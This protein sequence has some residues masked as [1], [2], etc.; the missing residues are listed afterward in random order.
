MSAPTPEGTPAASA[1]PTTD[2]STHSTTAPTPCS[3]AEAGLPPIEL[4]TL[5]GANPMA[6]PTA[7]PAETD[8]RNFKR[9][10]CDLPLVMT[11]VLPN[12]TIGSCW[13]C[14]AIEISEGGCGVLSPRLLPANA[15][16]LIQVFSADG[17]SRRCLYAEVHH[18]KPY[19]RGQHHLIG[20]GF[21]P[22]PSSS[23]IRNWFRARNA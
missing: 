7:I 17:R 14:R 6:V 21:L 18:T 12:L 3:P 9:V 10:V 19:V 13:E 8:R 1:Y 22:P 5:G 11:E 15:N 4:A 16:V 23:H 2:P 20:L